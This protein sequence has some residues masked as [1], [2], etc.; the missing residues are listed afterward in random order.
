[1]ADHPMKFHLGYY[2]PTETFRLPE[3]MLITRYFFIDI[4]FTPYKQ[5]R[6]TSKWFPVGWCGAVGFP[7]DKPP[8]V[9]HFHS[10]YHA[11][12]GE[13]DRID[14]KVRDF[15]WSHEFGESQW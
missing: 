1:M 12:H 4:D 10:S 11:W 2:K 5:A 14:V 7:G 9:Y 3:F 15:K 8:W 6:K 13:C